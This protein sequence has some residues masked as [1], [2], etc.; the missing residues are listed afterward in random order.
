MLDPLWKLT[1]SQR[2]FCSA[3]LQLTL[4]RPLLRLQLSARPNHSLMTADDQMCYR[5]STFANSCFFDWI[6]LEILYSRPTSRMSRLLDGGA[7]WGL[8]RWNLSRGGRWT[9]GA[10]WSAARNCDCW[11]LPPL[12]SPPLRPTPPPLSC[13]SGHLST[14]IREDRDGL[15]QAGTSCTNLASSL[16]QFV[17]PLLRIFEALKGECEASLIK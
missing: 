14:E 17:F 4:P 7:L 10:R 8:D 13:L 16:W 12:S 15:N 3:H 11:E 6:P 9:A 5:F 1:S 2:V